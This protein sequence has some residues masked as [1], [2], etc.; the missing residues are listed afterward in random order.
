[1]RPLIADPSI[2]KAL[3]LIQMYNKSSMNE[4]TSDILLE[5]VKSC[6]LALGKEEGNWNCSF[7]R[8][9]IYYTLGDYDKALSD[10]EKAIDK[11]DD[12]V[13]KHFYLRALIYA[14]IDK[15]K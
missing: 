9:T 1:M 7:I 13:I 5:S 4:K 14:A 10:I 2:Y 3:T 11:S 6:T 12:H 15:F 8:A